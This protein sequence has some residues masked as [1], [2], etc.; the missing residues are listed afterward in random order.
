MSAKYPK[1]KPSVADLVIF[2][3]TIALEQLS[4]GS[5]MHLPFHPGR[6]DANLTEDNCQHLSNRLPKPAYSTKPAGHGAN[7][8]P[9]YEDISL[10]CTYGNI[11][12]IFSRMGLSVADMAAVIGAGHGSGKA[13]LNGGATSGQW[14]PPQFRLGNQY[15]KFLTNHGKGWCAVK[16][17]AGGRWGTAN[18]LFVAGG[19]HSVEPALEYSP[20]GKNFENCV[21]STGGKDMYENLPSIPKWSLM[22]RLGSHG[23]AGAAAMLPSDF[24][25]QYDDEANGIVSAFA[26]SEGYFYTSL[27]AAWSKLTENGVQLL[28]PDVNGAFF[29]NASVQ[30]MV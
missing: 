6:M 7:G 26:Y 24:A 19:R 14:V 15:F 27:R 1:V 2:A 10:K 4:E 16:Q 11:R 29:S 20:I 18:A 23:V 9:T 17:S 25:L 22:S 5:V 12:R 28:C 8:E 3:S 30:I 21:E 13:S